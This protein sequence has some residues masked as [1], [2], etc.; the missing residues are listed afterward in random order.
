MMLVSRFA[1]VSCVLLASLASAQTMDEY[2]V[3]AGFVSSFASYVE[4]PAET[5]KGPQEP[6]AI[7]VLGQNPFGAALQT[8]AEGKVVEGRKF[9]IRKI[10]DS[11][12]AGDCQI[13]YISSSEHLRL[14]TIL[15]SLGDKSVFSV[16]DTSDFIAEGGIVN[17]RT[18]GG[19]VSIEINS[20]AAKAK[21]LRISS[22][23]LQLARNVRR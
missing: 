16:G 19:R 13:L 17:L 2:Q 18:D 5:F 7:C 6:I 21:H 10:S 1:C 8:L 3:K 9:V 22:R 15:G 23:L 4:W 14:R 12:Q 11:R 20:E